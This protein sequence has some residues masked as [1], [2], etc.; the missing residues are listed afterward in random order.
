MAKFVRVHGL[1]QLERTMKSLPPRVAKTALSSAVRSGAS[2]IGKEARKRAPVRT[3]KVRRNI[4]W[5]RIKRANTSHSVAYG[6][7]VRKAAW[8]WWLLEF[9]TRHRAATPFLRPAFETRKGA[10]LEAIRAK[11]KERIMI[12]VKRARVA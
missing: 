7:S 3:G 2:V 4:Y 11:L 5:F 6:V 8:Y 1:A 10:A 9:G 12:V